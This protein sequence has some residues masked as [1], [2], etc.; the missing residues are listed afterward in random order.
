MSRF[1]SALGFP[2][3]RAGVLPPVAIYCPCRLSDR[4]C[5]NF[6]TVLSVGKKSFK[7]SP[8]LWR[9]RTLVTRF[10]QVQQT[11]ALARGATN[12]SRQEA[13]HPSRVRGTHKRAEVVRHRHAAQ[14]PEA[15]ASPLDRKRI[16]ECEGYAAQ[17]EQTKLLRWD[18]TFNLQQPLCNSH[19]AYRH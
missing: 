2:E 10:P 14:T 5:L 3:K 11:G 1:P 15:R 17:T 18:T 16:A 19:C 8:M 13:S 12:A 6:L 4:F 9:I 7:F